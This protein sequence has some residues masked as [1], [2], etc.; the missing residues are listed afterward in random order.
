MNKS[1]ESYKVYTEAAPGDGHASGVVESQ[2]DGLSRALPKAMEV[3]TAKDN[4]GTAV[5]LARQQNG[6]NRLPINSHVEEKKEFGP[7]N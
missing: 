7:N 2:P 1:S 3:T 5:R 4:P 6:D